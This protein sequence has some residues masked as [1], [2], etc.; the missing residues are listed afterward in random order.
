VETKKEKKALSNRRC[1]FSRRSFLYA[2]HLPER[3][4]IS[5]RRRFDDC[6]YDPDPA[7]N[8]LIEDETADA[9]P[10]IPFVGKNNKV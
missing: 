5:D 10:Q 3:R 4:K 9:L 6:D 2:Y 8:N 1:G 7:H